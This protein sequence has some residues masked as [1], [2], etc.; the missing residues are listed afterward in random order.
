MKGKFRTVFWSAAAAVVAILLALAFR[1]QPVPVD[2]AE[3]TRGPMRVLVRAEGRTRVRN[4]YV[5]SAPIGGQ[6]M[7]VEHKPGAHVEAGQV[8]ARILPSD[9]SLLDARSRAELEAAVRSA[10]A[11]L[12]L[13]ATS[14]KS[15]SAR[16]RIARATSRP[17]RPNPL[18][19]TLVAM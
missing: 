9:P 8:L 4:E 1:P 14:S 17:M 11:A 2:L 12:S 13:I 15:S 7:R 6:H 16:S 3:V 19:A 18:I 5:V 10:E